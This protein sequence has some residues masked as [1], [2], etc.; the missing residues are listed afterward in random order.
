MKALLKSEKIIKA[1]F[2]IGM[3]LLII[4]IAALGYEFGQ[5]LKSN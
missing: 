1:T 3:L 5:W 4:K 2:G